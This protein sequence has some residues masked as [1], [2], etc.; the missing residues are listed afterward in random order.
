MA[1]KANLC[2]F[3]AFLNGFL[4]SPCWLSLRM[5]LERAQSVSC[6][7][8]LAAKMGFNS[9]SSSSAPKSGSWENS[10]Q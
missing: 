3:E 1:F 2:W 7:L 4:E 9:S 5:D 10:K 6:F 8:F